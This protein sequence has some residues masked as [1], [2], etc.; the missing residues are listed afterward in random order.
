[1]MHGSAGERHP[2]LPADEAA[3]TRVRD[4][5]RGQ[6]ASVAVA[7]DHPLGEGW[8]QLWMMIRKTAFGREREEAVVER[9]LPAPFVDS[10]VDP[11]HNADTKV[12]GSVGKSFHLGTSDG[13][14]VLL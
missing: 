10:L 3:N 8:H 12:A 1:M 2:V 4:R 14:A 13:D 7:P 5:Y 11:N 6:S 9:A